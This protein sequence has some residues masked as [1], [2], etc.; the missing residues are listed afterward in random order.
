MTKRVCAGAACTDAAHQYD[1]IRPGEVSV[2]AA[3]GCD[4]HE[5]DQA[6]VLRESRDDPSE[7]N[8]AG[9]EIR[10]V[11]A[12]AVVSVL[13]G[14]ACSRRLSR[15]H[16]K[17][18]RRRDRKQSHNFSHQRQSFVQRSRSRN[19]QRARRIRHVRR[20]RSDTPCAR[21]TSS[22]SQ[23][24]CAVYVESRVRDR[25]HSN[26]RASPATGIVQR[27]TS[28]RHSG[29][30]MPTARAAQRTTAEGIPERRLRDDLLRARSVRRCVR[31]PNA[32]SACRRTRSLRAFGAAALF[33]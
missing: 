21:S 6:S 9:S 15:H 11:G 4:T 2:V 27:W 1:R 22:K 14:H 16:G 24:S 17:A 26:N 19:G 29:A 10:D 13:S 8:M 32:G 28:S 30:V 31:D 33:R 23:A 25:F 7:R 20:H 18:E 5:A 12:L 3:V